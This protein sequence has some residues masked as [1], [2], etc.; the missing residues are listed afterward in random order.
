MDVVSLEGV[1]EKH[2]RNIGHRAQIDEVDVAGW[3][4]QLQEHLEK[5]LSGPKA[6]NDRGDDEE[7][8]G[9]AL[10]RIRRG[11]LGAGLH[12]GEV[13]VAETLD[14]NEEQEED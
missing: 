4:P 7:A 11:S 8:E 1:V 9:E 5:V 3:V 14:D 2:Y 13:L 12:Q 6:E 10:G